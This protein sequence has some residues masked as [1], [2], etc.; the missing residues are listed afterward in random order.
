[1]LDKLTN[2]LDFHSKALML[3]AERQR[4]IASNIA[5]ADTPNYAARDFDFAGALADAVKPHASQAPGQPAWIAAAQG[6][7][8]S[9]GSRD[10]R[11]DLRHIALSP[12]HFDSS[13]GSRAGYAAQTQPALDG[14]SV[15]LDR[16]RAAFVDNAVRYEATLRFINGH[17]KTLLAAIQGQ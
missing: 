6:A 1:M 10:G 17:G 5:N 14:N 15:D 2:T 9:D 3:R 4:N 16:E 8:V 7:R 13:D 12:V 11:T